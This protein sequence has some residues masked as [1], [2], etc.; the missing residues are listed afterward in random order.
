MSGASGAAG[1]LPAV[2]AGL[3]TGIGLI[4]VSMVVFE[5]MNPMPTRVHASL[6]LRRGARE[7]MSARRPAGVG[8][9]LIGFVEAL[10]STTSSVRA[11]LILLG[12]SPD[13]ASFRVHQLLA[14][15][16]GTGLAASAV[17]VP[18]VAGVVAPMT[19]IL[20]VLIGAGTGALGWDRLLTARAAHRQ[21]R[22]ALQVP[23]A[24][25]LLA[26][27]V[28]AGES[29]S[30]ALDRV[31]AVVGS[32]LGTEVSRAVADMRSGVS[33]SD[34]LAALADRNDVPSLARL[35]Q[36]LVSAT[37]RGTPLS[38]VLRD[39]ASDIREESRRE[40]MERSGRNEIAML[41][42][43]VFLILPVSVLFALY[44]GFL[45]LRAGVG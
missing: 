8:S 39:Q 40:L 6:G 35:A 25:E 32:D 36:T 13:A 31:A 44:P 19:G 5:H 28:S 23:D 3:G 2:I 26:L 10:G 30:G 42:P 17:A 29:V 7:S 9:G 45:Q 14:A 27:A 15:V 38:G 11:R 41:V 20:P 16:A 34:A 43:V 4:L 37:E 18:I 24:S 1:Y 22:I 12:R 33:M 21:Q